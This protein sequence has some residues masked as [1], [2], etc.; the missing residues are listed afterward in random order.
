MRTD[1]FLFMGNRRLFSLKAQPC[2]TGSV[3]SKQLR[4]SIDRSINHEARPALMI[5]TRSCFFH[6]RTVSATASLLMEL[7]AVAAVLG[8]NTHGFSSSTFAIPIPGR[9]HDMHIFIRTPP[10]LCLSMA[11]YSYLERYVLVDDILYK[12]DRVSARAYCYRPVYIQ[13]RH[14]GTTQRDCVYIWEHA[15][16]DEP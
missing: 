7:Q 6:D 15:R 4:K 12:K 10:Y 16:V 8:A 1:L 3:F 13:R 2:R 11:S 14:L 9:D 5:G